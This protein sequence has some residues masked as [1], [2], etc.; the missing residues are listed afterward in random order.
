M[1]PG[2]SGFSASGAADGSSHKRIRC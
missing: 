1:F 2:S